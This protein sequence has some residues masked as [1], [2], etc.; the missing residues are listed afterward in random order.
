MSKSPLP[1]YH[2]VYLLLRQRI[3]SGQFEA[4][5]Q[6][7]GENALAAEYRVSRLTIRR[8]LETLDA[9]GLV[10][11][12]Q[13]RG[14]FPTIHNALARPHRSSDIES[15]LAHLTDMATQ[16][17][18]TLLDFSYEC[19]SPYVID[20]L[21]LPTGTHVQKS[22]R[23]RRY[24]GQPFSYLTAYVPADIGR[25]YDRDRLASTPLLE[26]FRIVGIQIGSAEQ[27]ITAVLAEPQTAEALGV[28]MGS[29]LLSIHR[30][31]RDNHGR[32]I[33][34]LAAAYRPDRYEYHMSLSTQQ[35]PGA[36]TWMQ[37][38]VSINIAGGQQ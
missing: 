36:R 35:K 22:I 4:N 23:L 13:G 31:V 14:T 34:Y 25:Q 2:K 7:P 1:L 26:V 16:T 38:G 10:L 29:P 19:A 9:D 12:R 21:E 17:E 20:Q 30:L 32:P 11:R 8:A 37:S 24:E 18:A 15:L 33:E 6:M 28:P 27:T 5:T 3:E